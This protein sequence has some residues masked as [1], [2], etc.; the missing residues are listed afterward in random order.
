MI[1]WLNMELPLKHDALEAGRIVKYDIFDDEEWSIED[2]IKFQGSFD[3]SIQLKSSWKYE[4]DKETGEPADTLLVYGNPTKFLQGHNIDGTEDIILLARKTYEFIALHYPNLY[5]DFTLSKINKGEFKITRIDIN[6]MFDL[7]NNDNV[8]N[9]LYEAQFHCKSRSGRAT[10]NNGTVYLQKGSTLWSISMY[11]KYQ[12]ICKKTKSHKLNI[13]DEETKNKL[14]EYVK[15]KLR[16]ELRLLSKQLIRENLSLAKDLNRE[17]DN[18]YK[19]FFERIEMNGQII[20]NE[21][22]IENLDTATQKVYYMYQQGVDIKTVFKKSQY[23]KHRAELKKHGI[24][25]ALPVKKE[26]SNIF[27]MVK[28]LTALPA[29]RPDWMNQHIVNF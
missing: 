29:K 21:D 27:P 5:N 25:I 2:K 17:I 15:G 12:E 11:N 6:K 26:Q 28:I 18:L 10:S 3:S 16:I 19:K 23:Y 13:E 7:M 20:L 9:W 1:D 4:E 22:D 24:D 14:T 8:E